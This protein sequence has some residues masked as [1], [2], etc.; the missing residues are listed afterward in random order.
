MICR[1]RNRPVSPG[2][3]AAA[4][5][6]AA[7]LMAA[8]CASAPPPAP[9][10]REDLAA[11]PAGK[12]LYFYTDYPANR[13]LIRTLLP[14]EEGQKNFLDGADSVSGALDPAPLPG[15][16][17]RGRIR[18]HGSFS[19]FKLSWG[20][21]FSGDWS[22]AEKGKPP[23]GQTADGEDPAGQ[24]PAEGRWR[25]SRGEELSWPH[26][27]LLIWQYPDS[28]TAATADSGGEPPAAAALPEGVAQ[29]WGR[30]DGA[31]YF[32]DPA[33]Y[34]ALLEAMGRPVETLF[35]EF[36]WVEPPQAASPDGRSDRKAE[37]S[38][39]GVCRD[40]AT[41]SAFPLAFRLGAVQI[42]RP[43]VGPELMA[44]LRDMELKAEGKRVYLSGFSLTEGELIRAAA[45]LREGRE[46]G[47]QQ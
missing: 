8:S 4:A 6:L 38:G 11:L 15:L 35:L 16:P 31:L 27:G 41:A 20:L 44:R 23:A 19:T 47:A 1:R 24:E 36:R 2:L 17:P 46:K 7:V 18:M 14:M 22:A 29:A 43:V 21:R 9:E 28:G 12:A 13:G 5:V 39:W 25:S 45:A 3:P 33:A 32:S 42:L 26:R 37:F 40:A 30:G 34:I 10:P